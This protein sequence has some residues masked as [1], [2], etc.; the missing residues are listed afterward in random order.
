M[1]IEMDTSLPSIRFLQQYVKEHTPLELQTTT[2]D[3]LIGRIAW[4]D[5]IYFC[6]RDDE[7]HQYLVNRQLVVYVK[8]VTAPNEG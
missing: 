5:P 2:G 4:Q 6:L 1:A 3:R 7:G 8:P